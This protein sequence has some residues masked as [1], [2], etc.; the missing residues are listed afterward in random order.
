MPNHSSEYVETSVQGFYFDARYIRIDHHDGISRFS[1]GL[2]TALNK[3]TDV[4]AIISDLRQLDKLPNGTKF[5]KVTA[6]TSVLEPLVALQLN[7]IGA[8]VV[9][10]P[11]QT[12]GTFGRRFKIVLTVHDLIYYSHPTPPPGFSLFVKLLWRLYHLSYW[13]QRLLLNRADAIVA[14]SETTKNL[15]Q[16]NRL[17][18]RPVHVVHNAPEEHASVS[19]SITR[20][21]PQAKRN[22][23]YMGSFMDY[24]NV[25]VL[26]SGMNHLPEYELH[27]LSRIPNERK[28]E[29]ESLAPLHSNVVF[30]NGTSDEEYQALLTGAFALVSGSRDEGFGIPLVE[31]MAVGTPIVVSDIEIF[32]EIG[33]DAAKFF[34]QNN[35]EEFAKEIRGLSSNNSWQHAS[36]AAIAQSKLF[37]WDVSAKKL[38]GLIQQ[39]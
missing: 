20:T 37:S 16:K 17:T 3:I 28:A 35:P 14:V 29:L 12:I 15:I 10:S 34:D 7:R 21:M 30:H 18:K 11:M 27:L 36:G 2:F 25:E 31:A 19:V 38:L 5:I 23:I 26:V 9:F 13:P 24:K 22:L 1:A 6:P 32:R 8:K 33:G 4:T 39:I